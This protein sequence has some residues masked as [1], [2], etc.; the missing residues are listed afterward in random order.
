MPDDFLA[1]PRLA[2][3]GLD[4]EGREVI[5]DQVLLAVFERFLEIGEGWERDEVDGHDNSDGEATI[6]ELLGFVDRHG[7]QLLE[8]ARRGADADAAA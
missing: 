4:V 2:H 5:D 7:R 1:D 8:L 3:T 6:W